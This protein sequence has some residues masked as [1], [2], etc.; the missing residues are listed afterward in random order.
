MTTNKLFNLWQQIKAQRTQ[1]IAQMEQLGHVACGRCPFQNVIISRSHSCQRFDLIFFFTNL[2]HLKLGQL[3]KSKARFESYF[4][5]VSVFL[6]R[7][8]KEMLI[9]KP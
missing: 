5:L 7:P 4:H 8:F 6:T 2:L 1:I 9:K 3:L